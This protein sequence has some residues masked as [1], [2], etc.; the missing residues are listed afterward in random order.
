VLYWIFQVND[1]RWCTP[2]HLK[3][4]LNCLEEITD[5]YFNENAQ[6]VFCPGGI[7]RQIDWE[8]TLLMK[9]SD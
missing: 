3:E 2:Q 9:N 4:F 7:N 6:G 8:A 1:K 5:L